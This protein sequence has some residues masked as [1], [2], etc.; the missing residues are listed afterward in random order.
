MI[1]SFI[2]HGLPKHVAPLWA[3]GLKRELKEREQ[4]RGVSPKMEAAFRR[5]GCWDGLTWED[6][7]KEGVTGT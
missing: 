3:I 2:I 4:R 7:K 6:E 1:T 5:C